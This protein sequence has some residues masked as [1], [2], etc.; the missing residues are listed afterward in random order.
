MNPE[1]MLTIIDRS[2]FILGSQPTH[3]EIISL[4]LASTFTRFSPNIDLVQT[5][6]FQGLEVAWKGYAIRRHGN[7]FQTKGAKTIEFLCKVNKI[8]NYFILITI[9][10]TCYMVVLQLVVKL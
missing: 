3:F 6:V 4:I 9:H 2:L 7:I 10:F 5:S 8:C 1:V